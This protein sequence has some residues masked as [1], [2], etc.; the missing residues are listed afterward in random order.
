MRLLIPF[1]LLVNFVYAQT[2]I[3]VSILPQQTFVE[4]IG[5]DKVNVVTMVTPG[6]NPHSYEPKP[7][8]MVHISW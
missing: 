5:A 3:V 1:I 4:K 6:S 7:S 8:Q 2:N